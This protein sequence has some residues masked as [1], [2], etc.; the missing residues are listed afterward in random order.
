MYSS[1]FGVGFLVDGQ[2]EEVQGE[3]E[4]DKFAN[5]VSHTEARNIK[6][7]DFFSAEGL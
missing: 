1:S 7:V 3:V 2:Q 5:Y 6:P 4:I